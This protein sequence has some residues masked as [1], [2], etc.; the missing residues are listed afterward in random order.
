[1]VSVGEGAKEVGGSCKDAKK[2]GFFGLTLRPE[3]FLMEMIYS[4]L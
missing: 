2:Q 3:D 1:L 4:V